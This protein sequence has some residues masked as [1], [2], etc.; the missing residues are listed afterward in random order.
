VLGGLQLLNLPLEALELTLD[1]PKKGLDVGLVT[2]IL[3]ALAGVLVVLVLVSPGS[4][5]LSV[6]LGVFRL[7]FGVLGLGLRV[8]GLGSRVLWLGLGVLGFRLGVLWLGA[9]RGGRGVGGLGGG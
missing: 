3:V 6:V 2:V 5:I 8:F 7:G 4:I 1:L 9:W